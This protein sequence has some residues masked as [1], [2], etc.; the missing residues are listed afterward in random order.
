[1][2]INDNDFTI[3]QD[4]TMKYECETIRDLESSKTLAYIKNY[5]AN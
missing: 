2:S 4:R 1:M 3:Q 5:A